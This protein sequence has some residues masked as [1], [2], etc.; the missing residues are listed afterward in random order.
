MCDNEAALLPLPPESW[1][2]W[3]T[4][5]RHVRVQYRTSAEARIDCVEELATECGFF[6]VETRDLSLSGISFYSDTAPSERAILLKLG[7][8]ED[9]V[10][11]LGRVTRCERD[12]EDPKRRF[13]VAC[14]FRQLLRSGPGAPPVAR[15][16]KGDQ[17]VR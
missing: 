9:S 11:I 8:P 10:L 15:R 17:G 4:R 14:T 6:S 7:P 2:K 3:Q 13:Q 16:S 1:R 5:R 12:F